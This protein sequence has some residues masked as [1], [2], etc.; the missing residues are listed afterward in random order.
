MFWSFRRRAVEETYLLVSSYI[1]WAVRAAH[2]STGLMTYMY[3][4]NLYIPLD[5]VR[6]ELNI[7]PA[8]AI[9]ASM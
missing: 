4:K 6:Q 7:E 8:P 3:E 1:P 5:I 9:L 2:R